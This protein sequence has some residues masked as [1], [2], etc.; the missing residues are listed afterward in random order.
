MLESVTRRGI[1]MVAGAILS[2]VGLGRA[3]ADG[4]TYTVLPGDT[5]SGIAAVYSVTVDAI[6]GLNGITDPDIIFPGD[7]LGIPGLG[8]ERRAAP[9]LYV[10]QAGDTLSSI[11]A[12]YGLT[13]RALQEANELGDLDLI[14]AGQQLVIP[15][16]PSEQP[17]AALPAEPPGDTQLEGIIDEFAA[18]EGL[19]PGMLKA[20]AYVESGWDQGARSPAGAVGV[21]QLMPDTAD[22]LERDVFG[23]ELNEGESA[24]DNVKAGARLLRILID[25]NGGDVDSALASYYQGQGATTAGVMYEDTRGYVHFVRGV[26]ERY[27]P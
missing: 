3:A 4:G 27:W 12:R 19:D 10:V 16:E 25:Q 2:L 23:Y 1:A 5:L 21:M 15:P 14:F 6:A 17:V 13:V 24:Y 18:V 22:W 9:G 8:G 7:V 26:W 11:A 20:V